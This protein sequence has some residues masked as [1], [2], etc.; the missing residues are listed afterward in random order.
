MVSWGK[1]DSRSL[2]EDWKIGEKIKISS[3]MAETILWKKIKLTS[4][5]SRA[6]DLCLVQFAEQVMARHQEGKNKF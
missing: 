2:L 4:F 6:K 3:N 1:E 5:D